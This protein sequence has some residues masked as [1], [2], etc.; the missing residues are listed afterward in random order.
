MKVSI[1]DL[2]FIKFM[3]Y[4]LSLL[5]SS[6]QVDELVK[7]VNRDIRTLEARETS[8]NAKIENSSEDAQDFN[9]EMA[10]DQAE[11]DGLNQEIAS[12]PAGETK[13][14]KIGQRMTLEARIYNRN[15]DKGKKN[16]V[17]V[18][19][20]EYDMEVVRRSLTAARELKT[21][22][23]ARKAELSNG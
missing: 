5:T 2:P 22:L 6:S 11:L 10:A 12:L 18:V 3:I 4:S 23:E 17:N 13:D 15:L 20:R 19:E 1:S 9:A 14:K 8:W 21:A 7:M 16:G